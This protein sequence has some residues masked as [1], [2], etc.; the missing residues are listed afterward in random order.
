MTS[1]RGWAL[2]AAAVAWVVLV[3]AVG[4][5]QSAF[6]GVVTDNTG[7]VMPGVTVEAAS[8]ALIEQVRTTVTD[9]EGRYTIV[10]LR[11]GTYRITFALTGFNTIVREGID[12]ASDFTATV[13][14][15]LSVGA[16]EEAITVTGQVPVVD[17]QSATRT[18][19][20]S[21]EVLDSIPTSRTGQGT[22]AVIVGIRL[23]RPDVGGTS[24]TENVRMASHGSSATGGDVNAQIDGI[25]INA[26]DDGGIQAYYNEAMIQETTFQTSS[27]SAE[28]TLGG[29]RMNMI[30][31]EGGN[32]FNGVAYIS[33]THPSWQSNNIT[34]ELIDRGLPTPN[35]I[36]HVSDMT[37][38]EGGPIIRNKIWFYLSARS[39]RLDEIVAG[40]FYMP[41]GVPATHIQPTSGRPGIADQFVRSAS[42]RLTYQVVPSSKISL[43]YDRAFKHKGHSP[44]AG[45]DPLATSHRNWRT[46]NYFTAYAKLTS[47]LSNR[48]LLES[49]YSIVSE[50]RGITDQPG[51]GKERGTPEWYA[52]AQRFDFINNR[53]WGSNGGD[54]FTTEE[55]FVL[56]SAMSLVT[57]SHN[58]KTGVQW[59]SGYKGSSLTRN[60]D[61]IQR[62]RNGVP[63]N[64]D[65]TSTPFN[66]MSKLNA[67]LGIYAQDN[68]TIDR[69]TINPGVRLEYF[70]SS[71]EE[72]WA[73]A[74]RFVPTARIAPHVPDLPEWFDVAPRFS[75]VYD[76]FGDAKTA[77]KGSVNKYMR[78]TVQRIASRYSPMVSD[79]DRRDWF[80]ADLIPGT[81]T[82]SGISRPTDGDD[83]AQDNEIGPPNKANFGVGSLRS[84]DPDL[85]REYN[86]EVSASIQHELRPGLSVTGAWYRRSFHDLEGTDN[87]LLDISDYQAFETPSPLNGEPV[88]IYNL[89]PA[90]RGLV[91]ILDTNSDTNSVVYNGFEASFNGRLPNGAT[92]FGGVTTERTVSVTCETD[93]PNLLLHCD[94]RELD[95]PFRTEYK[96]A[97]Y[98][99]L[100]GGFQAN[101]SLISWPGSRLAVNWS[102]P[103]SAFPDGQRTQA[104]E[105]NLA[106]P[107]SKHLDRINQVDVGVKKIFDIAGLRVH[108]N[109]TV[110]NVL[111]SSAVLGEN[112]NFGVRLGEPTTTIQGRLL[113]LA[114]Q[115]EW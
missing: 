42:G 80:D 63:E 62:Y 55:R 82:R 106:A 85:E 92:W 33:G 93:D 110:F 26:Q 89:N 104:V 44:A 105:V 21:R 88:T 31:R 71:L 115:I 38:S 36:A 9:G 6:T 13:N 57:G 77:L 95:I 12:L 86:V 20:M 5:T 94:Q 24:A 52:G 7:A 87:L 18:Q 75:V 65:V 28:S 43:Y 98:Y 3:P 15:Q 32:A 39:V 40:N 68:W 67:D 113:R 102:V 56:M 99:P 112:E 108:A 109:A 64:V 69:L 46:H 23:N 48:V 14:V 107:G 103:A 83:I 78:N 61:L 73:A 35:A 101:M 45:V 2:A 8:P 17:V 25:S 60:A 11:P 97:G 47:A 70:N 1:R 50:N 16:L 29:V 79:T 4:S 51:V 27:I 10:Q 37:V 41:D 30:P 91:H 19:V 66:W 53:T 90:K 54:S 72:T 22:G 111:N 81:S 58:F 76:L 96:L 114:T 49:G 74:G 34:Q 59:A 100:P 84:K